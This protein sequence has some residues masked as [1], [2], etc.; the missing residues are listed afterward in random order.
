M[1]TIRDVIKILLE[2]D[3]AQALREFDKVGASAKKNLR[4]ASDDAARM[5]AS[6]TKA[7]VGMVGVSA[8]LGAG[9]FHAAEA[10]AK[11]QIEHEKLANTM[12]KMPQLDRKSTRLTPVTPISRMPSSA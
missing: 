2:A 6:F 5:R 1:T 3:G 11:A 4:G 10:A 12:Q 9:L 8:T 7:G